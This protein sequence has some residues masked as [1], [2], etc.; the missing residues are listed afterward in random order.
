MPKPEPEPGI[1]LTELESDDRRHL[2]TFF[3][4]SPDLLVIRDDQYR[5]LRANRAWEKTLGYTVEEL[6]GQALLSFV[7]PDDVTAT[8]ATMH[9]LEP[10]AEVSRFVNRYRRR[11]GGYRYLE[12]RARREGALT[13][14][15]ARDVTERLAMEAEM[16]RAKTEAEAASKAKSDFLANMSHEIRTPLNGVIGVAATLAQTPLGD[17]QREMVELILTSGETLERIVSDVLDFSKI[18]AGR[19]EIETAPFDLHAELEGLL[20]VFRAEAERKGLAFETEISDH[21]SGEYLGDAVRMKQVLGNLLSNAVKFTREGAV[22]VRAD[23]REVGA[24]APPVLAFEVEDT[25][26]GFDEAFGRSLFER[27]SQADSSI[28]RRFGGTGLGLSICHALV[29][30]MGGEIS[31]SST[32]GRGSLF[33]VTLPLA[34]SGP[35]GRGAQARDKTAALADLGARAAQGRLEVLL[36]EDH[37]INRRVIELILQPIGARLTQVEDGAQAVEACRRRRFDL[38]LMDMQMPVMDGLTATRA[39][40]AREAETPGAGRTPI[41]MLTANA[42]RQHSEEARAAGA[43][44][45]LAKPVTPAS[46]LEAVAGLV[47]PTPEDDRP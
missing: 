41:I 26:I 29:Q 21:A 19:L 12:W 43:D 27:F 46:L 40:R 17:A 23:V 9:E 20:A 24:G 18:E 4:V 1:A 11:D 10:G 37:E 2:T 38:V 13:Y 33:R 39:I 47:G 31:A 8:L 6:E 14:G 35:P 15:V 7:H 16:A 45:H 5:I 3:E 36:A 44:L 22:R 32:P 28:T 34:R 25:G 42:M 30:R